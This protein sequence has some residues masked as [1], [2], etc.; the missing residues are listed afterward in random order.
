MLQDYSVLRIPGPT[1]IPPSVQSAISKPM[2]GHR[3]KETTELLQ[4]IKPRVRKLFGTDQDILML[5]GSGTA[6]LEASVVNVVDE[7][8]EVLVVVTGAF[9]DRYAKICEKL[10]I[11]THRLDVTWGEAANP[12]EIKAYLQK[13]PQIKAVFMTHC[14]T[15]TGVLNPVGAISEKVNEVS[16]ALIIVDSVSSLGG[17]ATKMDDWGADIIVTGSQ[18]AMMLPPGLT[19]ISVSDRAW[20]AI[21]KNNRGRFY[22]DLQTYR[23][24]IEKDGVPYTPPVPL[25]QGLEQALHLIESE[26]LEEVYRRHEVMKDMTRAAMKAL[27]VPLLSTDEYASPTVTAVKPATFNAEDMRKFVKQHFNMSLAG[28]QQHLSGKVFRIG[29]MGY[30]SPAEVLQVISV[31]EIALKSLG[32][33]ITLGSGMKSAQEVLAKNL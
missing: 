22:F 23:K 33:S 16:D 2:I 20:D 25:L 6:G 17:V 21:E 3:G 28:G 15:S 4:R 7:D 29:H 11:N 1:P 26:G 12:E 32:E 19:L 13:S 30:C 31:I 9:G 18:K 8:E 14:E 27:N 24:N 10:N 5:A